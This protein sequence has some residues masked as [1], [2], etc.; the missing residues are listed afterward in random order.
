MMDL[1]KNWEQR[2]IPVNE[3]ALIAYS[4]W[5]TREEWASGSREEAHSAAVV[6]EGGILF[7]WL[8]DLLEI[9]RILPDGSR[10]LAH[11]VVPSRLC[12]MPKCSFEQSLQCLG[13]FGFPSKKLTSDVRDSMRKIRGVIE[14][15]QTSCVRQVLQIGSGSH[16]LKS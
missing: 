6:G 13:F 5:L 11:E 14:K 7:T 15:L 9:E 3:G 10:R 12:Y 1:D 4:R 16:W 2:E 8:L